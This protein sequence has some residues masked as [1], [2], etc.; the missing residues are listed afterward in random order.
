MAPAKLYYFKGRGRSQQSR[1]VLAASSIAFT[2]VCLSTSAEFQALCDSGK[3]AYNQVPMLEADGGRCISQ[4]MAIVRHAARAGGLYGT[5]AEEAARIDEVLDGISDA[6][7]A[8]VGYPFMDPR[9]ACA[10]LQQSVQKFFPCFERIVEVT[11]D[12]PDDIVAAL[13]IHAADAEKRAGHPLFE[14]ID[15]REVVGKFR[16]PSTGDW[17]HIL[18]SVLRRKARCEAAGE[19]VTPATTDDLLSEVDRLRHAHGQLPKTNRGIYL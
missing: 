4:S 3:L 2:N 8:I 15:W 12:Y 1:W 19:V 9:E 18:H 17:I 6:R 14:E 10:R 5:C 7:G 11:P 16:G 13:R